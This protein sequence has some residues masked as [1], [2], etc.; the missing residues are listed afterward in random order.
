MMI[1]IE[2]LY[3]NRPYFLSSICYSS[4]KYTIEKE[5]CPKAQKRRTLLFSS[6]MYLLADKLEFKLES[7][8]YKRYNPSDVPNRIERYVDKVQ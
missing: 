6:N 8:V 3:K 5:L 2:A 4:S 1:P 7:Y